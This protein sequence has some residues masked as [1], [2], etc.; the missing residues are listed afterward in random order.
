MP[1]A[2]KKDAERHRREIVAAAARLFRERGIGG[3]SVPEVTAAAGLT[4]G[5]F[6]GQ[7][8]SKSALA[9]EAIGAA[10]SELADL[11]APTLAEA[12][13]DR[14]KAFDDLVSAY[15]SAAHRDDPGHGCP[16]AALVDHARGADAPEVDDAYR[17]SVERMVGAIATVLPPDA[18][19]AE[20]LSTLASMVGGVLLARASAGSPLSDE[21]LSA[22]RDALIAAR[23]PDD[24]E[25]SPK[26]S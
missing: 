12:A 20:A 14:G 7:F 1:R 18:T 25:S 8:A 22:T 9:A 4:H 23:A 6:Y 13:H 2:S 19:R 11:L 5:G 21:I 3:V 17:A 26:P 10:S 16:V 15:V 24:P